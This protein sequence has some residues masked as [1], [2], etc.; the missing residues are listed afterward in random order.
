MSTTSNKLSVVGAFLLDHDPSMRYDVKYFNHCG[1]IE[2]K[3]VIKQRGRLT[4]KLMWSHEFKWSSKKSV[5]GFALLK[6]LLPP[7]ELCDYRNRLVVKQ[8]ESGVL[9]MFQFWGFVDTTDFQNREHE[10]NRQHLYIIRLNL[11][12]RN[13]FNSYNEKD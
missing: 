9:E 13:R 2:C 7:F 3:K 8:T 6:G 5:E 4:R 1:V 12:F 10:S 11:H